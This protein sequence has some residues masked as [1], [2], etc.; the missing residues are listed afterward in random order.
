MIDELY[1]TGAGVSASSG[2]PTFRGNDGFWTVGSVN[3]TPQ[4]MATRSMYEN[5]PADFLLWYFKRFASYRNVKPNAAHY[6]LADKKLITQNIDGLDGKAGNKDYIS[7]HGR[8]DKVVCYKN[9]MEEQVPFDANWNEID[10]SLN[11]SDQVL[12]KQLLK[13]FKIKFYNDRFIPQEGISLKPYVLLFDEIYT[14]LYRIS[15][16]E[17]W[18][19]D[20][21]KIIFIGTSFSVNITSIAL[22]IAISRGIEVE[23]VDPNP[24]KINYDKVNYHQMN[25]EEYSHSRNSN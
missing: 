11:P 21:K 18:M 17:H 24:I 25:A 1:I 7:I 8:L 10:L 20:A 12:K 22:R 13:K 4:E 14:D 3:Y 2:I 5:N 6:W 23:I 9:E 16:A 19:N 15:E